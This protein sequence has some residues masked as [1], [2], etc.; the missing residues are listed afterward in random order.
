MFPHAND[1]CAIIGGTTLSN[2]NKWDEYIFVGDF[3]TGTIW[4]INFEKDSELI[5]LEKN[6]IPYSI[7]T[8]NDSGNGTLY[9]G[10]TSGQ[11]LETTL[12]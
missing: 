4:A 8:I 5:V 11:I 1:Y 7:T 9:I 2:S 10:T 6:L 3:C 12:P